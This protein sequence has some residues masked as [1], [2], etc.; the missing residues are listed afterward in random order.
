MS[1]QKTLNY[2]YWNVVDSHN[3]L[4]LI[5]SIVISF[6]NIIRLWF[7]QQIIDFNS[8]ILVEWINFLI[9]KSRVFNFFHKICPENQT[10]ACNKVMLVF[11][12]DNYKLMEHLTSTILFSKKILTVIELMDIFCIDFIFYILMTNILKDEET[13]QWLF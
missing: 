7:N 8:R 11:F 10:I 1:K 12:S 4:S 5:L 13:Q 3:F 6:H 9:E 2:L